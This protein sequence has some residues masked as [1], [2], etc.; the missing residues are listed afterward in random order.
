MDSKYNVVGRVVVHL[1]DNQ[2]SESQI[3]YY[4]TEYWSQNLKQEDYR[5]IDKDRLH[6]LLYKCDRSYWGDHGSFLRTFAYEFDRFQDCYSLAQAY[7]NLYPAS[8]I[9]YFDT[10]G[11]PALT[12]P[13]SISTENILY[14]LHQLLMLGSQRGGYTESYIQYRNQIEVLRF[15]RNLPCTEAAVSLIYQFLKNN[16]MEVNEIPIWNL[17]FET[18]S[19]VF[20]YIG[21]NMSMQYQG[22]ITSPLP[23]GK[24]LVR[25]AKKKAPITKYSVR[26]TME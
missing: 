12:I 21:L 6:K 11:L 14:G 7:L 4:Y 8:E 2:S 3:E 22:Y 26:K 15:G 13:I 1:D 18:F 9:R 10:T 24:I 17:D 19:E 20:R 25:E 5:H 16:K 23:Q